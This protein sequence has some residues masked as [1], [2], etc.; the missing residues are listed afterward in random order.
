MWFYISQTRNIL[1]RKSPRWSHG[2]P[3]ITVF[4]WTFSRCSPLSKN[5]NYVSWQKMP[6]ACSACCYGYNS[7]RG[8]LFITEISGSNHHYW[9]HHHSLSE[10]RR[11][12]KCNLA[13]P[14][15]HAP[16][17]WTLARPFTS[18]ADA[19]SSRIL[20]ISGYSGDVFTYVKT[21]QLYCTPDLNASFQS[22]AFLYL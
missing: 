12:D 15:Y 19:L 3:F 13:F 18:W 21:N 16:L 7:S 22:N 2:N 17:N 5:R 8:K 14:R 20:C 9:H 1:N 11:S 6:I 4:A 10:S